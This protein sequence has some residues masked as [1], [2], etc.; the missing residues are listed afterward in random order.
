M[1]QTYTFVILKHSG[2]SPTELARILRRDPSMF[3]GQYFVSWMYFLL[4]SL[5]VPPEG[6]APQANTCAGI[7]LHVISERTTALWESTAHALTTLLQGRAPAG[8]QDTHP[9]RLPNGVSATTLAPQPLTEEQGE[10][11]VSTCICSVLRRNAMKAGKDR[12]VVVKVTASEHRQQ[13]ADAQKW[14]F[15]KAPSRQFRLLNHIGVYIF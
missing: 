11:E 1:G 4:F 9:Q 5:A 8:R 13:P 15:L 7:L 14:N 12:P 3:P 6:T 10:R 2:F